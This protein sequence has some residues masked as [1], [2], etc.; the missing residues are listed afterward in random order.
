[1]YRGLV[2]TR[3]RG[4]FISNLSGP[5]CFGIVGPVPI[6]VLGWSCNSKTVNVSVVDPE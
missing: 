6:A 2:Q 3:I 1:M 5:F 4:P